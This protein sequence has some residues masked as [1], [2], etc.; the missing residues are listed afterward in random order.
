MPL[1]PPNLAVVLRLLV[2]LAL[3]NGTPLIAK[4]LLGA[5]WAVP[6]DAGMSFVDGRPLFGASKTIRGIVLAALA[7]TLGAP[8][9]G[10][11]WRLG[12]VVGLAAMAGD[13]FSSFIKRR[14]NL[15]PSSR[16]SGLDQIPEALFPLLA[17]R[18][19]LALSV[20]DIGLAVAAFV[21]GEVVLSLLFFRLGLRDRPY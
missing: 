19:A 2:L 7:T 8:L 9:L 6:A 16:A 12:L 10:V 13:L 14:L 11:S 21:A 18:A 20:T 3:A 15:P 4:K 17:C 5:R 1:P